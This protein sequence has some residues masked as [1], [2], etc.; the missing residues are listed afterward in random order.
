MLIH[1]FHSFRKG[2][3]I[4][5][6]NFAKLFNRVLRPF[7][8]VEILIFAIL[9]LFRGW[10][11]EEVTL[12]L[13]KYGGIG[14]GCY[15]PW[16]YVQFVF[17]LWLLS[18]LFRAIKNP[19]MVFLIFI[20]IAEGLEVFSCLID[21]D[22]YFY[23]LLFFRYTFLIWLGYSIITKGIFLDLKRCIL[24]ALGFVSV[25]LFHYSDIDFEPFFYNRINM[26][27][28]WVSYFFYAFCLLSIY[29]SIYSITLRKPHILRF[30]TN[31]G[32]YSYEIFLFQMFYFLLPIKKVLSKVTS[33][34]VTDYAY[35]VISLCLCPIVVLV[36]KRIKEN[37][38]L[39]MCG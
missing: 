28:H 4:T 11:V 26:S 21:L 20:L 7:F 29:Y 30:I 34:D 6:P 12:Q 24:A 33:T 3:E 27:Y 31:C 39:K 32:K 14:K 38:R 35:I 19:Y 23:R 8:A 37:F 22:V 15:F 25:Y 18:K 13:L 9:I 10:T 36:Y 16:V 5:P 1:V 2:T 17:L